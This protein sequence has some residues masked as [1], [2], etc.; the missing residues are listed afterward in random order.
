VYAFVYTFPASLNSILN[1][2]SITLYH[3]VSYFVFAELVYLLHVSSSE[4]DTMEVLISALQNGYWFSIRKD[5]KKE[6]V[7]KSLHLLIAIIPLILSYSV[8]LAAAL[9]VVGIVLY[10]FFESLRMKGFSIP[11]ISTITELAARDRDQGH[12]VAGPVT[13]ALG[14]L[15]SLSVFSV[16]VASMAIYALAFGDGLSSLAGKF[17]GM[18][19]IPLV[20]GKSI[21]GSLTCFIAVLCVASL[22]GFTLIPSLIIA[23]TA[24]FLEALPLKDWDNFVI[25][26]GTGAVVTFLSL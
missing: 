5:L 12:F 25:P 8:D 2:L 21:I 3:I 11:Y 17:L 16:P 26:I 24:A 18:T 14:A 1:I 6:V 10:S 22:F 4:G 23:F 9:L 19:P 7:R 20:R 15:V 13:L